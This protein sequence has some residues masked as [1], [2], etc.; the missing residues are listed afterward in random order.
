MCWCVLSETKAGPK[1]L[2]LKK[3]KP[4]PETIQSKKRDCAEVRVQLSKVMSEGARKKK[5]PEKEVGSAEVTQK[6]E[7]KSEW[8][9][10]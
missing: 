8:T 1:D 4:K 10:V 2:A 7:K 9:A 6:Q 3:K 5:K